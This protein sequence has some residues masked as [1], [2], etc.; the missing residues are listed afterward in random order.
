MDWIV[1][2][3]RLLQW[4]GT[5]SLVMLVASI[6][7]FI[8]VIIELPVDYFSGR[9]R[10][11]IRSRQRHPLVWTA[12]VA[13]K[14]LLGGSLILIGCILL[15]L[16][17]QGLLT[18]LIGLSLTNFPGKYAIECKIARQRPIRRTINTIRLW[19]GKKALR[20]PN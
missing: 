20:I 3:Q 19:A 17:G 10:H 12:L 2:N 1:E 8:V 13:F 5:I 6:I 18:I 11:T 4:L 9:H 14:N 7:A 15:L 16:P